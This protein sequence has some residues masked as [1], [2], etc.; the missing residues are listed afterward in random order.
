MFFKAFKVA[1]TYNKIGDYFM[2]KIN[3][4]KTFIIILFVLC[5]NQTLFSQT[6]GSKTVDSNSKKEIIDRVCKVLNENY[7]FPE[8]AAKM[9]N[10]IQKQFKEKKYRHVNGLQEFTNVLTRDLR[11]ICKDEHLRISFVQNLPPPDTSSEEEKEKAHLQKVDMDRKQ[12]FYFKEVKH[13]DDNIGY[14]RFDKFADP[15]YAGSTAVAAMNYLANCEALI[16]DLRYNGGGSPDMVT[17]LLSFFFDKPVNFN[18]FYKRNKNEIKQEWT[19]SYI[20]G[21][22]LTDM[23]LYVLMSR[24][25]SFS[26]AEGFAF[27]LKNLNRAT[28][29]GET[30]S[31]GAHDEEFFYFRKYSIQL[32]IPTRRA[33]NPKTGLNWEGI[34]VEPDVKTSANNAFDKAY[35]LALQN[36]IKQEENRNSGKGAPVSFTL[37]DIGIEFVFVKGGLFKMGDIY[38]EGYKN[39]QPVH[40]VNLDDFLI[41]KTEITFAQYDR[42]CEATGRDKPGDEGWGRGNRPVINV[43]WK[44]ARDFC[45]WLSM[46]INQDIR[47]PTEA[48]WEYA[49]REGGKDV[50]FGNGKLIAN[51][52]EINFNG[53]ERYKKPYSISGINR[54]KT[55]PVATFEPNA[56]GIYDM[57]GNVLEWCS[58]WFDKEFYLYS[59]SRNPKGPESGTYYHILKGGAW[60]GGPTF[61]RCS[62][63]GLS[64]PSGRYDSVGFRI[65][66]VL[67]K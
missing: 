48:E 34:G 56:L 10:F 57:A 45:V 15:R 52:E 14:L 12:N 27:A 54:Q 51:P 58:D 36:F 63:R 61:L 9:A 53:N 22:K 67:F 38:G 62:F 4:S 18:N 46:K 32:K 7:I 19:Y 49:A 25:Y 17:F 21:P 42:F 20:N 55:I 66:K 43:S 60:N 1:L 2:F 8:K 11:S 39:E 41:S 30:T 29:V 3:V 16:I 23:D 37:Q 47:L 59:P 13:L 5:I 65:I 24:A 28:I 35:N 26:A 33:Y 31:G 44:D 40:T 50:R 64:T 6:S